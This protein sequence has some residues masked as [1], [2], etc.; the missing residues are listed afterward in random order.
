MV[1]LEIIGKI[2]ELRKEIRRHEYLYFVKAQPEIGDREFDLLMQQ[3]Q[4]LE[5]QHPTL[6]TPDSPTQR[7]GEAVTSFNTVRHRVPMMS[8]DNSYSLNDVEEWLSRL[9][10]IAGRQVFPIVAELKID[11]VSGSFTYESGMLTAAATRGNGSEG[12]LITENARTIRSLP[13]KIK[14]NQSMDIRGEIYTPRSILEKLNQQRQLAGEEPFKNCRN[15]TAG[16]IKSLDP[17]VAA[18]RSLQTMVYGIAQAHELGFKAHSETLNFLE[19]NGFKINYAWQLCNSLAEIRTFI[20]EIDQRR[21]SFDFD[22]DGI[23]LK[24]DSLALQQELGETSKAPR[25]AIAY[26]YPQER[27]VSRLLE[28]IWQVGRSQ[29]TP[30]AVLEPVE[31][32]GTT[33]SRASLHNIDQIKEKDI[34]VGDSV[35]VEK[36][37]YIIPYIVE[38]VAEKRDG[39]EKQIEI[40]ES[41]PECGGPISV[42]NANSEDESTQVSCENPD[43]RGVV[44]RRILH[45]ITQLEIED[46]GP[47]LIEQ[48]LEK[49]VITRVEDI[50]QLDFQTLLRLDRMGE[51]SAEKISKNIAGAAK[52]RLGQLISA[53]GIANVGIVIADNI[54]AHFKQSLE[55]FLQAERETLMQIEGIREKVADSII[56]FLSSEAGTRLIEKISGWW[57]GPDEQDLQSH[58]HEQKLPGQIFVVTGE[59]EI[60]RKQIEKLIKLHGGQVKASVSKNTNFLLIGSKETEDFSSSKKTRAIELKI[61]IINEWQLFEKVGTDIETVK[62]LR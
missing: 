26:K 60:G 43:C 7:V 29:L 12:D 58:N 37:G 55:N 56:S 21:R 45:F 31:L 11:G 41:C 9:E 24:V 46:F 20:E 22:I 59:A 30:V 3:L 50:L 38:V 5:R 15:L 48:L 52:A 23:V 61:P 36:A 16:T 51:K 17:A 27:A 33:V 18:G 53:L 10:K 13:L 19:N 8:I 25:W 32:G 40:P 62:S 54:A 39:S 28:V 6:V 42:G 1:D 14:G 47:Q 2:E 4:E 35:I 44:A 49:K 34:R 57:Q